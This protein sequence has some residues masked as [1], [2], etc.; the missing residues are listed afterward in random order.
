MRRFIFTFCSGDP[1][2]FPS[3]KFYFFPVVCD[4]RYGEISQVGIPIA[5]K[6]VTLLKSKPKN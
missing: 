2:G 6:V 3:H 5:T 1:D 4:R